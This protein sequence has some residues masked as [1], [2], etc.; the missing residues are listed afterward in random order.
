[1]R[2]RS[3]YK[4]QMKN[5]LEIFSVAA[6]ICALIPIAGLAQNDADVLDYYVS[7]AKATFETRDPLARGVSY[8]F[9][10]TTIEWKLN[11]DG[12]IQSADSVSTRYFYSFGQLDSQVTVRP[13][14]HSIK[15]V[16]LNIPN[17]FN[18]EYVYNFFPND[19]G[20]DRLSLGFDSP[21]VE[22]PL[23]TGIVAVDRSLYYVRALFMV[24]PVKSGY[25][26]YSRIIETTLED[27]YVF[28]KKIAVAAGKRGVLFTDFYRR[29]TTI[30]ELAIY[31]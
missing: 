13:A 29:E 3:S 10:A 18:H 2:L 17:I 19:S 22:S 23:P 24:Y 12:V 7:R 20:G 9:L 11:R 16:D 30:S 6:V 25:D 28:P 14:T 4:H 26:R 15:D 27:G 21:S 1:V 8:S 31:R 5:L